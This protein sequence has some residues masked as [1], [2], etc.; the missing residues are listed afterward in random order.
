MSLVL[1]ATVLINFGV[2]RGF[3]LLRASVS[4]PIRVVEEVV[5]EIRSS[6]AREELRQA[7]ADGWLRRHRLTS[8]DERQ[9]FADLARQTPRLGAGERASLAAC[10]A[11]GWTLATDDRDARRLAGKV[12]AD[13]GVAVTGNIGLLLNAIDAGVVD[14]DAAEALYRTMIDQGFRAPFDRLA[15]LR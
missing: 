8:P 11:H 12:G 15:D 4:A 13:R 7:M 1:D 5:A 6:P 3:W 10:L 2:V 9:W 14:L